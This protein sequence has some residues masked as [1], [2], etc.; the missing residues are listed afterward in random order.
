MG[1]LRHRLKLP[2]NWPFAAPFL[3]WRFAYISIPNGVSGGKHPT[4][5]ALFEPDFLANSAS[6]YSANSGS[7]GEEIPSVALKFLYMHLRLCFSSIPTHDRPRDRRNHH[8]VRDIVRGKRSR[9]YIAPH[10]PFRVF[11][12]RHYIAPHMPFRVFNV[13]PFEISKKKTEVDFKLCKNFVC[14]SIELSHQN[15]LLWF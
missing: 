12:A 15:L 4:N 10:M 2:T 5:L 7:G 8:A 1:S 3:F 6:V 13:F 11:N 14:I 9:H